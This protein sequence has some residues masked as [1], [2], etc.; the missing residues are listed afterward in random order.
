MNKILLS[1]IMALALCG[2]EKEAP[3]ALASQENPFAQPVSAVSADPAPAAQ[4]ASVAETPVG[5]ATAEQVSALVKGDNAF[6]WELF[7]QLADPKQPVFFSPYSIS[8]AMAML[9]LG[10]KGETEKQLLETLAFP[11]KGPLLG[12]EFQKLRE[13]LVSSD[14]RFTMTDAN[15]LWL[16]IGFDV[17]SS[18]AQSLKEFFSGEARSIEFAKNKEAAATINNWISDH[19]RNLIKDL[20]SPE[21]LSADTRLVLVNAVSFLAKWETPFD[22]DGTRKYSLMDYTGRAGKGELMRQEG[23]INAA[24]V[25][26]V[27]AVELNYAGRKYSLLA[28]MPQDVAK[29]TSWEKNIDDAYIENIT[30]S[31]K[32]ENAV[33]MF[34]KFTTEYS[35]SLVSVFKDMGLASPFA[36]GADFTGISLKEQL[37]VSEIIHKAIVKIY[38]T[39]TEAAAATAVMVKCTGMAMKPPKEIR[40]NKPFVYLIREKETGAILFL[41]HYTVKAEK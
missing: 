12:K 39:G 23:M 28:M 27:T 31:L 25:D 24:E 40:F 9:T 29:F 41:G 15:S 37:L 21:A 26:G 22:E 13:S 19:T 6:A 1:L 30:K 36:Y 38:E 35:Q 5:P 4:T 33:L 17:L 20:I 16:N 34:P 3:A 32:R 11:D 14:E 8:S 2:C 7:K 10:A 18:Y